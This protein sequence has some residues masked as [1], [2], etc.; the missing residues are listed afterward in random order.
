MAYNAVLAT[1]TY[2]DSA[3][4]DGTHPPVILTMKAK[5]NNGTLQ[6]GLIAAK[7][8]NGDVVAYDSAGLA[9][10]NTPVGVVVY[11]CDTT[12]DTSVNVLRHGT[13]VGAMLL[14]GAVAAGDVEK[15]ALAAIGIFAV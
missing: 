13:V 6:P 1:K 15:A 10:I 5:A 4:I 12:V 2:N 9:P 7:D 14:E 11:P 8:S 3:V